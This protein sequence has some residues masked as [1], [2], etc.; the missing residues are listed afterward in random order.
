MAQ[1]NSLVVV[2]HNVDIIK[3]ADWIIEIGPGS[4]EK[5]GEIL[6]EGTPSQIADNPQS[7]IGPYLNGTAVL[8][9]RPL[10]NEPASQEITFEVKDY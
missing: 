9:S 5:G 3:E 7:K 4:G 10:T 1:G 6:T 2:D 8:K